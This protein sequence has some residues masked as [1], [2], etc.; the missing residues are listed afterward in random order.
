LPRF[1]IFH[2]A[3]FL[4]CEAAYITDVGNLAK[5]M[6]FRLNSIRRAAALLPRLTYLDSRPALNA[7]AMATETKRKYE[8]LVVVPDVAGMMKKRLEVRP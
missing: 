4:S 1:S 2:Q 8:W 5:Y 3:I 6:A 7:R